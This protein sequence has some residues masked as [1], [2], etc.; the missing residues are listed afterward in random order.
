VRIDVARRGVVVFERSGL[1]GCGAELGERVL[2]LFPGVVGQ[3]EGAGPLVG[4]SGVVEG[5]C[6]GM[7]RVA[8]VVS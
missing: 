7:E 1:D 3:C 8:V 2:S 6:G 4:A 5:V